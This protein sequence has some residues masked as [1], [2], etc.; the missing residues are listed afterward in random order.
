MIHPGI[1]RINFNYFLFSIFPCTH[2]DLFFVPSKSDPISPKSRGPPTAAININP[3]H[4]GGAAIL[5]PSPCMYFALTPLECADHRGP[6]PN[7]IG[8]GC[9]QKVVAGRASVLDWTAQVVVGG[10]AIFSMLSPSVAEGSKLTRLRCAQ[11]SSSHSLKV[12]GFDFG[13]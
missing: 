4:F 6:R 3:F 5:G 8:E 1:N 12:L 9:A 11:F 13:F 10:R 2:T 7:P